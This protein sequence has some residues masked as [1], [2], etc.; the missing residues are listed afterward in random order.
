LAALSE[1]ELADMFRSR[2]RFPDQG[3]ARALYIHVPVA[4]EFVAACDDNDLAILGM[5]GFIIGDD[6]AVGVRLDMIL[7]CSDALATSTWADV[8]RTCNDSARMFLR[9]LPDIADLFVEPLALS[10]DEWK[11]NRDGKKS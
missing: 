10:P 7:D 3:R 4:L 2:S 5:E 9:Q 11:A 1:D 8:K 6:G